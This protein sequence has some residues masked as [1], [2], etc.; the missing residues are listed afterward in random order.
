M[1][2][3]APCSAIWGRIDVAARILIMA[4]GTGGH[5]FPALAVARELR[6]EGAEVLWLGTRSGLEAEIVPRAGFVL[7]TI[8]IGGLRGKGALQWLLLPFRLVRAM[9]QALRILLQFRP[10]AVLGMGG[11]AAGPGG[12]M[13]WLLR[14]P[15]LVHE[16]NAVA[17]LTNRW[18][19]ALASRCMVA[20]PGALPPRRHPLLIGNPV[21]GEIAALPEPAERFHGRVGPLRLLVLGGSQGARALNDSLPHVVAAL[22]AAERPQVRHQSGRTQDAEVGQR[23]AA[24]GAVAEVMPFIDDMAAAYAWADLVVCRAGAL[25]IAELTA[26]GIG[27]ILVPFPHAADDHQTRNA[28]YLVDAGAGILLAQD[29]R[30]SERLLDLLGGF[31]RG[32]AGYSGRDRIL[33]MAQAARRLA[34]PESARQVAR[35]CLEAARG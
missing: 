2:R 22:P 30:L 10:M 4:G 7:A 13:T 3:A 26:A 12:L 21:R 16:Q 24:L 14:K 33:L 28:A 11:F 35:L 20:F 29:D 32:A 15:L 9:L 23:Y 18:L 5:V 8:A 25:T 27:A 34:Q 19:A 6:A 17:G 1:N 31:C